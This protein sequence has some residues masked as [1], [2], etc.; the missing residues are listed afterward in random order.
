ML[1]RGEEEPLQ[2]GGKVSLGPD[3]L[4]QGRR[5]SFV[6]RIHDP[7]QEPVALGLPLPPPPHQ[8]CTSEQ[9]AAL[10]PAHTVQCEH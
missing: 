2:E 9:A 4:P 5:L 3:L 8:A 10:S 7:R 1:T 6:Q